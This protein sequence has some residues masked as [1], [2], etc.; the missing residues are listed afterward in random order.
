MIEKFR[1]DPLFSH[2]LEKSFLTVTQIDTI[3]AE[4]DHDKLRK[5]ASLRMKHNIS[6]GAF[7]R[8][9]R[10]A[11]HNIEASIYTLLLLE[12]AHLVDTS[13]LDQLARIGALVEQVAGVSSGSEN[14]GQLTDVI[15]EFVGI[16]SGRRKVKL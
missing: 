12:Y 2:L 16:F 15:G 10:Q 3:L 8:S 4:R 6:S 13:K 5:R 11:Q 7:L 1:S 14:L 9:L